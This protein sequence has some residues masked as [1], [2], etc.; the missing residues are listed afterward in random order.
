MVHMPALLLGISYGLYEF[1]K[2]DNFNQRVFVAILLI[3]TGSMFISSFRRGV[4]NIPIVSKNLKDDIYYG[5]TPDWQN[6]LKLS[7]WCADSLPDNSLIA[8]RKAPMSFVYGK[9]K[10]FYP[11]YSVI[12]RDPNSNQSN[13]DSALAIFKKNKV[14][15]ILLANL[16]IDP[17][18]YTG[19]IINTVHNI[20][21]PIA[22]KYPEKLR[23]VK[24]IGETEEASLYEIRY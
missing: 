14:T 19:D 23:L 13:P 18:K 10:H 17:T 21:I 16:R 1:F 3:A 12:A 15:H 4:K 7:A 11:I 20:A 22:Q 24:T 2:K 9:G 6:Y 5:Y 8:C